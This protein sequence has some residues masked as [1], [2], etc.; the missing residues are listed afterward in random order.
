TPGTIPPSVP[1]IIA[2]D[3]TVAN[4]N[5]QT[6]IKDKYTSQKFVLRWWF[7][8]EVYKTASTDPSKNGELEGD[9]GKAVQWFLSPAFGRYLLYRDPGMPLGSTNFTMYVRNDLAVKVGMGAPAGGT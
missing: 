1:V 5:F 6:A 9:L 4:A 3:E 2:S 8:E 7:P